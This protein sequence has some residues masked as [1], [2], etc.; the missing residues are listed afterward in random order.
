[1]DTKLFARIG[2]GAFV[3]IALTMTALQLREEPAR[4]VPEI[5]TVIDSEGDPL[6]AMLRECAA[7]GEEALDVP[8]CRAAWSEKRRRFLG[9]KGEAS[10]P[11][12]TESVPIV[13]P[14]DTKPAKGQ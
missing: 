6:A 10:S 14:A 9:I 11:V 8:A 5:E 12:T 2:A 4:T 1:M 3:A 13:V 7:M